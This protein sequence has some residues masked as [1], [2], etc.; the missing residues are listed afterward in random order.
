MLIDY[1]QVLYQMLIDFSLTSPTDFSM[2]DSALRRAGSRGYHDPY[3]P[4]CNRALSNH[5]VPSGAPIPTPSPSCR[6]KS[7][8][9][10]RD[11][12]DFGLWTLDFGL[13]TPRGAAML[14]W[15]Y[16]PY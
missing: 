9:Q 1:L 3:R 15:A 10:S 14:N 2:M 12:R 11:R 4:V 8:V 7:K 16:L 6:P 13:W 5:W